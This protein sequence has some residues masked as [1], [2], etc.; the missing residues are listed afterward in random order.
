MKAHL[1]VSRVPGRLW[2][3]MWWEADDV[4]VEMLS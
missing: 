4:V 2:W 3:V 1:N